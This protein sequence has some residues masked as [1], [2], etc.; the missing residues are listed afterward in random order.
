MTLFKLHDAMETRTAKTH[1]TDQEKMMRLNLDACLP[2]EVAQCRPRGLV[3]LRRYRVC[4]W[5]RMADPMGGS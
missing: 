1:S 2:S 3:R 4:E 5:P